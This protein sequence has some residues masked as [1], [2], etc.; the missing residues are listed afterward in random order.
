MN[1][2]LYLDFNIHAR[3]QIE[4]HQHINCL[5]VWI[6]NINQTIVCPDFIMLVRILID[7]S[8]ATYCKAFYLSWQ[9]YRTNDMSAGSFSSF[10]N[11]FCGLVKDT[12]I[13]SLKADSNLLFSHNLFQD[14]GDDAG[15]DGQATFTDGELRSLL[16]SNG[17]DEFNGEIDVVP[18]HHHLHPLRQRNVP[19]HIHRPYVELRPI[20]REE[21]LVPSTF[22]LLQHIYLRCELLVRRDRARLRQHL[23]ALHIRPLDTTQQN[24]RIIPRHHFV[25][26]LVEHLRARDYRLP[27]LAQAD[28]LNFFAFL[29]L[30][31]VHSPRHHRP[32]PLDREHIL[33]RH[34][35][36]LFHLA[37]RLGN[38]LVNHPQQF[39]DARILRC[40]RI[41]RR[42]LQRLQRTPSH[43]RD[44]LSRK[45]VTRQQL[46][47]FHF[48]QLQQLRII[49][50]IHFV[51][52]HHDTRHF[53]LTR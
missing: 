23:P 53:H 29:G 15:A 7:K 52:I 39:L 43:N 19:R 20:A 1:Y 44:R 46:A 34:H 12:M 4:T 28:D 38:V 2:T 42:A 33:N 26:L 13:I 6:Q 50:L 36:R 37:L 49:H 17:N 47:Q 31:P 16:E 35:E 27:G 30:A 32:A 25:Q 45:S 5:G 40:I 48:D 18:R 41:R 14:F 10:D 21:R 22:F 3:R 11:P 24:A 8:R 51:Q 9:G